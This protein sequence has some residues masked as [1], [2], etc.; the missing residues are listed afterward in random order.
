MYVLCTIE[1]YN[2]IGDTV[3]QYKSIE[4]Y[5]IEYIMDVIQYKEQG[6]QYTQ[7]LSWQYIIV[8]II[9][10]YVCRCSL[11]IVTLLIAYKTVEDLQVD[12]LIEIL[13]KPTLVPFDPTNIRCFLQISREIVL[14]VLRRRTCAILNCKHVFG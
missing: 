1:I 8:I 13:R 9:C 12:M 2:V 5:T 3:K 7:V 11:S 6:T 4:E 14:D 10:M